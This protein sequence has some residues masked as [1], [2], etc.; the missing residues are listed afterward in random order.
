MIGTKTIQSIYF[1]SGRYHEHNYIIFIFVT[2]R[3]LCTVSV[4][5]ISSFRIKLAII[6]CVIIQRR[7][8]GIGA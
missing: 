3:S 5:K 1:I 6:H 4:Y 7:I 2:S 8:Q